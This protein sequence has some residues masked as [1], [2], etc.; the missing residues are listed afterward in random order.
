MILA[1]G[2]QLILPLIT[3]WWLLANLINIALPP[4][5]NLTGELLIITS[6]FNWSNLTITMTGLGTLLTAT[7]SLYM[8]LIAQRGK[9]PT[10]L[11]SISPTHTREHLLIAL[12]AIPTLLLL[13]KPQLIMGPFS[14]QH[15]LT[16]TLGCGPRNRSLILLADRRVFAHKELLI[17]CP[18]VKLPRPFNP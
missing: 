16:K 5:I 8:F 11:T 1:R 6:T 13:L 10:H 14:C 4:T 7:Y 17:H 18:G 3:A 2:L 12:H 15:S 9:L